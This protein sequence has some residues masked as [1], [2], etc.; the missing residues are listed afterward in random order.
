MSSAASTTTWRRRACSRSGSTKPRSAPGSC[1]KP[2]APRKSPA[3][4]DRLGRLACSG[5]AGFM[6][7]AVPVA[8]EAVDREAK[9]RPDEQADP[10]LVGEEHAGAEAQDGA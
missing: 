6:Q 4:L 1:S 8:V 7:S 5:T 9:H 10:G 2:G 3:L